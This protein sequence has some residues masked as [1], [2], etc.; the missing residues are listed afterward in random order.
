MEMGDTCGDDNTD[1]DV[2]ME[3]LASEAQEVSDWFTLAAFRHVVR[4]FN[5]STVCPRY[6]AA[7]VVLLADL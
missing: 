5:S 7:F 2:S 4:T 3:R 1:M 6:S